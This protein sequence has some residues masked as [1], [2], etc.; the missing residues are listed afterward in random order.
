MRYDSQNKTWTTYSNAFSSEQEAVSAAETWNK[1]DISKTADHE[2][3]AR[4]AGYTYVAE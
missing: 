4:E 3:S 2:K 1:Q